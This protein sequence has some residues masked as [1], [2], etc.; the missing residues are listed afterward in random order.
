M[1]GEPV[2]LRSALYMPA[3]N[4]RALEKARTLTADAY[5]FDLEDAVAPEGKMQARQ[6]ARE[7][8][9]AGGY[10]PALVILRINAID[11]PWFIDD[12][13]AAAAARPHA[14]LLPKVQGAGDVATLCKALD[15][16]GADDVG[17]W[18]MIESPWGVLRVEDIAAH[19]RVQCLVM[20]TNDL[21]K[22]LTARPGPE[23]LPL[24]YS[25]SRCL[26]AAR[27]MGIAALDGVHG[28]I[29]DRAGL[30]A[31]CQQG[32]ALGFDGKTLIHPSHIEIANTHYGPTAA[33][34]EVA[35]RYVTAFAAAE[36]EG[37]GVATVD[38]VMIEALHV[39][40][41]RKT[42]TLAAAIAAR[43]GHPTT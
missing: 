18:T 1:A 39:A 15:Q 26:L 14:V 10:A 27:A 38:G 3:S 29:D 21:A 36:A 8:C 16:A 22:D 6:Q 11:S 7:A 19:E 17:I 31:V 42:L 2:L 37:K 43:R 40:A 4:M 41:A 12:V 35:Q 23:R 9:V 24:L 34:I 20:G 5:I 30:E 33:D 28:V 25:L 32:R 13:R